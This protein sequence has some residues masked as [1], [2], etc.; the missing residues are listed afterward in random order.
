MNLKL[1][2]V[3]LTKKSHQVEDLDAALLEKYIGGLGY[4]LAL[5]TREVPPPVQALDPA[6]KLVFATGPLTGTAMSSSG[7]VTVIAK[8]PINQMIGESHAGTRWGPELKAAGYDL[9]V[10]EGQAK[11]PVYLYIDDETVAIE[12]A[13]ELWGKDTLE[14]SSD[15]YFEYGRMKNLLQELGQTTIAV[16]GRAGENQVPNAVIIFEKH[17]TAGACG[18]GAVMGS[19]NLK[20]I[21]VRGEKQLEVTEPPT[22]EALAHQWDGKLESN[23]LTGEILPQIGTGYFFD[24]VRKQGAMMICSYLND[25]PERYE[26]YE[27]EN[28][29]HLKNFKD[30]PCSDLCRVTKCGKYV[31]IDGTSL[32]VPQFASLWALGPNIGLRDYRQI[33]A[34]NQTCNLFGLDT[35]QFSNVVNLLLEATKRGMIADEH[36]QYRLD[37]QDFDRITHLVELISNRESVGE[38][39]AQGLI[40]TAKTLDLIPVLLEINGLGVSVLDPGLGGANSTQ[41]LSFVTSLVSG[42]FNK[43]FLFVKELFD[44]TPP[45][46][47]DDRVKNLIF[48]EDYYAYLDSLVI[49]KFSSFAFMEDDDKYAVELLSTAVN[50]A[51][52]LSLTPRE[53]QRVGERIVNLQYLYNTACGEA[54]LS[55]V[56]ER[57][58]DSETPQT[59]HLSKNDFD[60]ALHLYKSHRDWTREALPTP[61]KLHELGLQ[62]EFNYLQQFIK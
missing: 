15:L 11:K 8:S 35:V 5:F 1:L 28:L 53:H 37:F 57:F 59:A 46:T 32:Y 56:P 23:Q 3:N 62:E 48:L 21:V 17:R 2:R 30:S 6:N 34:L 24:G 7:R 14:A 31:S 16:I 27:I 51:T 43:S 40:P 45:A 60:N 44:G 10:V 42:S 52:G 9:L 19:K 49:C 54:V 20:A 36:A 22:F 41:A 13:D 39:L 50:A 47:E 33:I 38:L 58:F 61:E 12:K 4:G 29:V 26:G 18:L 25:V 55:R